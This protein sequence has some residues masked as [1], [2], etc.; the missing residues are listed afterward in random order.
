[1]LQ[2]AIVWLS[3]DSSGCR[4]VQLALQNGPRADTTDLVTEMHGHVREMVGS[5][6]GNYVIQKVV[7]QM[8][9]SIASF[10][11]Q[12]LVASGQILRSIATVAELCAGCWSTPLQG[13][14]ISWTRYWLMLMNCSAIP[15]RTMF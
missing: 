1:M 7:E 14:P 6:H 11:A 15:L 5:P 4:A 2:G 12:E 10:V 13:L 9:V 3:L 8:P